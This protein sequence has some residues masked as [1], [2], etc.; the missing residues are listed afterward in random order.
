[1]QALNLRELIRKYGRNIGLNLKVVRVYAFQLL[2][3]RPARGAGPD[4]RAGV[5]LLVARRAQ[6][7]AQQLWLRL[8]RSYATQAALPVTVRAPGAS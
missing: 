8:Q 4:R 1:M 7:M 3:V 6:I 2:R 5:H